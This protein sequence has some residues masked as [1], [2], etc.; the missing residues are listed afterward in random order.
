MKLCVVSYK[1]CWKDERGRW[2]SSGGFPLQ[3][4]ALASLFEAVTLVL[5]RADAR[6]GGVELPAGRVVALTPPHGS[7]FRRKA[8]FLFR[9]PEYL[10]RILRSIREADVVHTPLPGDFALIALLAAVL[11][12]K[13]VIAR[14]GGSWEANSETTLANRATKRLMRVLAGGRNVMLATGSGT[15]PPAEGMHWIFAT[16]LSGAELAEAAPR[17][18]RGISDPPRLIYIGRLSPEKGVAV[19]V[20]AVG[21]LKS[22]GRPMQ[23]AIVG[24]GPERERLER[25]ARERGCADCFRFFGQLGRAEL[26]RQIMESDFCVQPSLT[27]GFSKA[28][29]DAMAGGLPVVASRVGS[30]AHVLGE[31]E[32]RGWLVP[33][34]DPTALAARLRDLTETERDWAAMRRRCREFVAGLTLEAWAAR[35]EA[36]CDRHWGR[37]WRTS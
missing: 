35:I 37:G 12:G 10:P 5:P 11:G 14:Y 3:M 4:A 36:I 15:A 32:E 1:E 17:L 2:L 9:L 34:G 23:I 33:P 7:N 25:L 30:A 16:T 13:R 19:L 21:V 31:A 24:D 8:S 18:D 22:E 20:E 28:W 6:E 26:L 29:L 27:E